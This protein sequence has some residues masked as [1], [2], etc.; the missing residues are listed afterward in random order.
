[1]GPTNLLLKNTGCVWE[2]YKRAQARE[3]PAK[4]AL[5]TRSLC[6]QPTPQ[7]QWWWVCNVQASNGKEGPRKLGARNAQPLLQGGGRAKNIN[8]LE[9]KQ[10]REG[11]VHPTTLEIT[12]P[13]RRRLGAHGTVSTQVHHC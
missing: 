12:L 9:P 8:R 2:T 5:A 11:K 7:T 1:M 4:L 13:P 10:R 6:D 3:D